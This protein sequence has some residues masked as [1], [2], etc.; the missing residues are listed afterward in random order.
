MGPA[1]LVAVNATRGIN[2]PLLV[3]EMSSLADGEAVP[4]P[5]FCASA[6]RDAIQ[7]ADIATNDLN[8]K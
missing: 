4:I 1:A 8:D 3:D 7:K 5:T 6:L 2:I